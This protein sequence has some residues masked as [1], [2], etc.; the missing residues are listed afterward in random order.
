MQFWGGLLLQ[1]ALTGNVSRFF[2]ILL[3]TYRKCFIISMQMKGGIPCE[4]VCR[5]RRNSSMQASRNSRKA[6][7]KLKVQA[8]SASWRRKSVFRDHGEQAHGEN[9]KGGKPLQQDGRKR[10]ECS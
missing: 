1:S 8:W 10:N 3:T 4:E 7:G 5:K 9:P 6:Q 2:K